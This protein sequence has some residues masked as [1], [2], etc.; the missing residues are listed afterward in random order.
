MNGPLTQPLPGT[1]AP[2]QT[3]DISVNLTTP[4]TPG[5]YRGYWKIRDPNGEVFA[6][7]SGAFWVEIDSTLPSPQLPIVAAWPTV[8]QGASGIVA[9]ALQHLLRFNSQTVNVDGIF[10][11]QTRAAVINFQNQ[12]G[13][14]ADGIV[15]TKTWGK[16]VSGAQLSQGINNESTIALQKLLSQ[17]YGYAIAVDGIFGPA[18]KEAVMDFQESINLS[19]DGTVTPSVWQALIS[20]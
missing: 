16:L 6:L 19:P 7:P 14:T 5:R 4:S 2:G 1:V 18:T 10:G 3:V 9:T 15:G 13:L 12:T 8:K 20:N 11:N 17:K